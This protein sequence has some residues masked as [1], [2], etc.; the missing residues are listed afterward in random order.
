MS[1][2]HDN[3]I[4]YV[5]EVANFLGILVK[6]VIAFFKSF[7]IINNVTVQYLIERYNEG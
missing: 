3:F 2:S 5:C 7:K 4:N 6:V 1:Q